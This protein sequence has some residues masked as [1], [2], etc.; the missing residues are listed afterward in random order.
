MQTAVA[1]AGRLTIESDVELTPD[2]L[3]RYA[4]SAEVRVT[5]TSGPPA[6]VALVPEWAAIDD[7]VSFPLAFALQPTSLVFDSSVDG[8]VDVR[9][10]AFDGTVLW[11]HSFEHDGEGFQEIEI[12][13]PA[14]A[15]EP[16][17]VVPEESDDSLRGRVISRQGDSTADLTILVQAKTA[18]DDSLWRVV[19]TATTDPHGNFMLPLPARRSEAAQALVSS[20]PD[21]V[22][23]LRVA[24]EIGGEPKI[25]SDFVFLIL[26]RIVDEASG[27]TDNARVVDRLPEQADLIRSGQ[28]SQ[29]LGGGCLEITTP[30]RTLSEHRYSAVVRFTDPDV[31]N[32]TLRKEEDGSFVLDQAGETLRRLPVS[33]HN[34][35]RWQDAPESGDELSFYQAVSV[36]TGHVLYFRSIL[37]ADGYS[38][39]DLVYTLPLAPGQKKQIVSYD[40]SNTLQAA[41]TQEIAQG[42]ALSAELLDDRGITDQLAGSID[43]QTS[44]R[45]RASTAGISAGLGLG[46]SI[47]AISGSLGVAGGYSRSSSSASQQGSRNIT[48]FFGEKLRQSLVQNAESYRRVNAS[49]VT[50]VRDGQ[51]Y[52]V[53]TEV[54]ANHNHCHSLTMMYF[55]VLRHYAVSQELAE[56]QEC[57]FVPLL[58]TNF[59]VQNVGRWKDVLAA[60][61]LP[62]PSKTSGTNFWWSRHSRRH[63]LLPAFDALE[64]VRTGYSRVDFPEGRYAEEQIR[65]IEGWIDLRVNLPRP[66]TRL[67]RVFSLPIVTETRRVS[68]R[69]AAATAAGFIFGGVLGGL[70]GGTRTV[71]IEEQVK[72]RVFDE[73]FSLDANFESVHPRDAIRVT[74]FSIKTIP[75]DGGRDVEPRLLPER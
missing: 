41:E 27:D 9:V 19:G 69:S 59:D 49:V 11:A 61:L 20:A 14:L 73:F 16:L 30:N 47:G 42:E 29:D 48:Q 68:K 39:G 56:V 54:V 36:A 58:L 15:P 52:A 23:D 33:L 67:D 44:G 50:T 38:L 43:E 2:D 25:A 35:I 28:F 22:T 5:R 8:E 3:A 64:R 65:S 71:E 55:E 21:S 4:L 10:T 57:L 17:D 13:V 18:V 26:D 74:D 60:N 34:P 72:E 40:V 53:S 1:G 62:V 12:A 51:E 70:F 24:S 66:A 32:F 46:G 7:P 75:G 37:K 6:V 45:S 31:A 63:P